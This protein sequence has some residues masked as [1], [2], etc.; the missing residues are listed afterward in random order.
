MNWYFA[1]EGCSHGPVTE[2]KLA[3]LARSGEV[4]ADTL[5]WHPGLEEW[6][7][8]WKVKPEVLGDSNKHAMARQA[9]GSTDRIPLAQPATSAEKPSGVGGIVR[10]LFGKRRKK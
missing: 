3:E 8:V 9:R 4:G 7:P 10:R 6:E 1:I 2:Q 5:I